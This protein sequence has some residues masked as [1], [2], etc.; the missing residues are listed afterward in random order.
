M[1][2]LCLRDV[3]V[4]AASTRSHASCADSYQTTSAL[5]PPSKAFKPKKHSECVVHVPF[6]WEKLFMSPLPKGGT[7]NI[8]FEA[9]VHTW[10]RIHH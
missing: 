1:A 5:Q 7:S 3:A 10:F 4:S 2:A 8:K 9:N 6:P